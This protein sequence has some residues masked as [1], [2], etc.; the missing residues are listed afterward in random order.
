MNIELKQIHMKNYLMILLCIFF[1]SKS[2]AQTL[3][4]TLGV[5]LLPGISTASDAGRDQF[6]VSI[7][8]LSGGIEYKRR[9]FN[10]SLYIQSGAY[11]MHGGVEITAEDDP[12]L[13]KLLGVNSLK[14]TTFRLHIPVSLLL[15]FDT[16]W[17]IGYGGNISFHLDTNN[18]VDGESIEEIEEE[19]H[20]GTG[21]LQVFFGYEFGVSESLRMGIEANTNLFLD[22]KVINYMLGVSL[23]YAFM[24]EESVE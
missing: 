4:S 22:D 17:Y 24:D 5:K 20:N 15:M 23:K 11:V 8:T 12:E 2:E 16:G 6:K 19:A 14:V 18:Y 10:R 7:P 21:G 3:N 13:F 1:Y 9:I